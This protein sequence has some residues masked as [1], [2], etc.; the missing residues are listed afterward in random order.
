MR[1]DA[2]AGCVFTV[3]TCQRAPPRQ[4]PSYLCRASTRIPGI[5]Y[6]LVDMLDLKERTLDEEAAACLKAA[7]R[8][9]ERGFEQGAACARD[10]PLTLKVRC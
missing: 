3:K 7:R 6:W 2:P 8:A 9:L 10:L 4:S 1:A 5:V